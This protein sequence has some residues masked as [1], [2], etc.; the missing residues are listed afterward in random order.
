M[1]DPDHWRQE[2]LAALRGEGPLAEPLA[3]NLA[4]QLWLDGRRGDLS[5]ALDAAHERLHRGSGEALRQALIG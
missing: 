3:W 4:V 1:K 2:A 5:D